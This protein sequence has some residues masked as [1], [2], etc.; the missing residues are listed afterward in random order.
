VYS[1]GATG[2]VR[3]EGG[4]PDAQVVSDIEG[5]VAWL[6]AQA[7]LNGMV[8]VFGTCSGGRQTF[9]YAWHA[10]S[11]NSACD[12]W[13]GRVVMSKGE[14]NPKCHSRSPFPL[15]VDRPIAAVRFC[16]VSANG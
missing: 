4:V 7:W 10:N 11:I 14:L 8:G 6:R 1:I 2:C 5:A 9:L 15:R 3:A 13:G 12:L 16:M